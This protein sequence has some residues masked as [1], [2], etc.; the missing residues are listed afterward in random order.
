MQT[1]GLVHLMTQDAVLRD[2]L[3]PR[4]WGALAVGV[5]AAAVGFLLTLGPRPDF[6]LA[7]QDWRFG[8]KFAVTGALAISAARLVFALGGPLPVSGWASLLAGPAIL[9]AAVAGELSLQPAADWAGLALGK[10]A[11]VCLTVIPLLSALPLALL[12]G[13]LR[14]G[15]PQRPG[16]AG[17]VAGVAAAGIAASLYAAHCTDD[18]PL[19]VALWYPLAVALVALT[20][21]ALGRRLLRW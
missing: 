8:M 5:L 4:L 16:L 17:A 10:N 18:S 19:F 3:P 9:A 7:L 12:L 14:L 2:R 13:V 1:A 21:A 11:A 20:G 15:A 6:A